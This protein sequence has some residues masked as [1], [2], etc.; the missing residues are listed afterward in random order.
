ERLTLATGFTV[1]VACEPVT[2]AGRGVGALLH[3]SQVRTSVP[4]IR[5][6]SAAAALPL[7]NRVP[8]RSAGWARFAHQIRQAWAQQSALLVMGETGTGKATIAAVLA[9]SG[10]PA[11]MLDAEIVSSRD[12]EQAVR[13]QLDGT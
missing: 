13:G 12:W 5:T 1:D 11:A 8:G 9:E 4:P 6:A 3:L 2:E 7:L 10:R